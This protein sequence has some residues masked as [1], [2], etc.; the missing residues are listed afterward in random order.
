MRFEI[1]K[2]YRHPCGNAMHMLCETDTYIYGTCLVAEDTDSPY[3][4][5]VGMDETSAENWECISYQEFL[6][7]LTGVK[8]QPQCI[9]LTTYNNSIQCFNCIANKSNIH[10]F[11][12]L[13][14]QGIKT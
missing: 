11:Y 6:D 9:E 4:K 13:S 2:S 3:L 10:Y 7:I 8:K 14:L 5:P 12:P 1:G